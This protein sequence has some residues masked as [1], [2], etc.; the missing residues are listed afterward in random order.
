MLKERFKIIAQ[1]FVV[2]LRGVLFLNI[3]VYALEWDDSDE[4]R[5]RDNNNG[6]IY[7]LNDDAS[8]YVSSCSEA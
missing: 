6:L 1:C 2:I 3:P 5:L 8:C 7:V 4:R